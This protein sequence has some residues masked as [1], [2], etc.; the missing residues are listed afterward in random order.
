MKSK[1]LLIF[2][3]LFISLT[4]TAQKTDDEVLMFINTSSEDEL[5]R[6]NSAMVQENYMYQAE[7]IANKLIS[8]FVIDD[9][10]NFIFKSFKS[11]WRML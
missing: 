3:A 5:V 6:E 1:F 9:I 7:M 2:S 10:L 8:F 4:L 11:I